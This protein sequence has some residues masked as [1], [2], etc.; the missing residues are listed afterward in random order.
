MSSIY[1]GFSPFVTRGGSRAVNLVDAAHFVAFVGGI[2]GF[3]IAPLSVTD[4]SRPPETLP[5]A[6][7]Y[8]LGIGQRDLKDGRLSAELAFGVLAD[9]VDLP[10]MLRRL[11][12]TLA[13]Y[14]AR[15]QISGQK[16]LLVDLKRL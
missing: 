4:L 1:A 14:G 13:K 10:S 15:S 7:V 16:L 6:D 12:A 5:K 11:S 8:V 9:N 2:A 3:D